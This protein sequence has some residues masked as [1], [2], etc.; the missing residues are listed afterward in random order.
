VKANSGIRVVGQ[1]LRAASS[2]PAA[3][4]GPDGLTL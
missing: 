4:N 3:F 2:S 1:I